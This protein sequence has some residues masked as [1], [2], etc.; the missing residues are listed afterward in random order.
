MKIRGKTMPISIPLKTMTVEEKIQAME[1][2]WDDLCH[3]TDE[4]S[5]PAWHKDVLQTRAQNV[6]AGTDEFIDWET[7]KQQINK[8][9]K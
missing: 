6:A 2:L 7:A 3:G 9:I 5:S 4:P 8:A 1:M